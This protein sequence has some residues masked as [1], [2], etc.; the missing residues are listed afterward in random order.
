[1]LVATIVHLNDVGISEFLRV[2]IRAILPILTEHGAEIVATFETET[3][4]ND[5]PGLPV[6]EGERVFVW[7]NPAQPAFDRLATGAP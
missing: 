3:S 2:F 1:M 7:L 5:F 4:P 6:R